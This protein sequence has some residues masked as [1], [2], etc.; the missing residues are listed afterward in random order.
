MKAECDRA[1]FDLAID[2][3][4]RGC[5]VAK[6]EIGDL[7]SGV[8]VHARAIVV[9]RKTK[10]PVQFE[11]MEAAR[12]SLLAWLE[13]GELGRKGSRRSDRSAAL[14]SFAATS[15]PRWPVFEMTKAQSVANSAAPFSSPRRMTG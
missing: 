14:R 15:Q 8:R 4:L 11:L 3:K 9:Q 5:D 6:V 1:L 10:K 7:V 2:R 12:T 13:R